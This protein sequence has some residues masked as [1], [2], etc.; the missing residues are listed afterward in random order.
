MPRY[1][2][3]VVSKYIWHNFSGYRRRCA[4]SYPHSLSFQ[5]ALLRRVARD[6]PDE[7]SEVQLDGWCA[8]TASSEVATRSQNFGV[9]QDV[10]Y[11]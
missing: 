11:Q 7:V 8:C 5:D 4:P 10:A 3:G 2:D 9:H 1:I 6:P